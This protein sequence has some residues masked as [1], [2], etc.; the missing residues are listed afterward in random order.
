M[1][2]TRAIMV[3]GQRQAA[4]HTTFIITFDGT[5]RTTNNKLKDKQTTNKQINNNSPRISIKY[6]FAE[7]TKTI[8][9]AVFSESSTFVDLVVPE[10]FG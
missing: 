6:E 10:V 8:S 3:V 9:L 5:Q 1:S 7:A 2:M 4:Q